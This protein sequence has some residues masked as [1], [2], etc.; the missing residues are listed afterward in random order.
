MNMHFSTAWCVRLLLMMLLASAPVA[1]VACAGASSGSSEDGEDAGETSGGGEDTGQAQDTASMPE[2]TAE[3]DTTVEPDTNVE[4]DTAE[5][6]T[7]VEDEPDA[8]PGECCPGEIRC[9]GGGA[10]ETCDDDGSWMARDCPRGQE[11]RDNAC[12]EPVVSC[13][14]GESECIDAGTSRTCNG[15]GDGYTTRPCGTGV[16]IGGSCRSGE[17]IMGACETDDACAGGE[18][19]CK[20]DEACPAPLQPTMG[21]GYCTTTDCS[22]DGCREDEVCVDFGVSGTLTEGNHCVTGCV[23]CA[24]NGYACRP[25]P[26]TNGE[27]VSWQEGCFPD[28]PR[29]VGRA[30]ASDSDCMGGTCL[31]GGGNPTNGYCTMSECGDDRACPDGSVCVEQQNRGWFCAR[32]CGDGTPASGSCPPE[33]TNDNGI[34]V[35]CV[36]L[37]AFGSGDLTWTCAPR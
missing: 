35:S 30:C 17:P 15:T 4:P 2:D 1:L 10:I 23:G 3:P 26:V 21:D 7:T 33:V 34:D 5:P 19:L 22:T 27:A 20:G 11:C 6:D 25:L 8:C 9:Q 31:N 29:R 16:C 37:E 18:C 36:F 28:Y 13:E 12:R 32:V 14:P 24:F